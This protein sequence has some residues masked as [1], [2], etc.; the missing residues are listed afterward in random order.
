MKKLLLL[1]KYNTTI[2]VFIT[3]SSK[4]PPSRY[5]RNDKLSVSKFGRTGEFT[6]CRLSCILLV[7]SAV[8]YLISLSFPLVGNPSDLFKIVRKDSRC[9]S[10]RESLRPAKPE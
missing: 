2:E 4:K 8:E 1:N 9:E 3:A 5:A 10:S 7:L 6:T